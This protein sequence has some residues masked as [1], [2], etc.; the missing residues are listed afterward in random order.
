M[1][2]P[3]AFLK[4]ASQ[5]STKHS[6]NPFGVQ[7]IAYFIEDDIKSNNLA[8]DI[9]KYIN[10]LTLTYV[11]LITSDLKS[12][13]GDLKLSRLSSLDTLKWHCVNPIHNSEPGYNE[14]LHNNI[15]TL[16]SQ[17]LVKAKGYMTST[18]KCFQ[19]ISCYCFINQKMF[20]SH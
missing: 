8:W 19:V 4:S 1:L 16:T 10:I 18:R 13:P 3:N 6:F 7:F 11:Y 15:L 14:I 20:L 9:V 17:I 5:Q 12:A 2:L